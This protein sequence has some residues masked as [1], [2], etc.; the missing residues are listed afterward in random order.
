MPSMRFGD[1][2]YIHHPP[3][4]LYSLEQSGPALKIPQMSLGRAWVLW[5]EALDDGLL[6]GT[7]AGFFVYQNEKLAQFAP[8]ASEFMR[9]NRV[10]SIRRLND[11]R[12]AVGTYQGGILIL[13]PEGSIESEVG[14]DAGL[15]SQSIFSLFVDRENSIWA[16][17]DSGIVRIEID[18]PSDIITQRDGLPAQPIEKLVRHGD[19]IYAASIRS[20]FEEPSGGK[21]FKQ[22]AAINSQIADMISTPDGLLLSGF[23]GLS[24]ISED[25]IENVFKSGRS[26]FAI[27]RSRRWPDHNLFANG[28]SILLLDR[29]AKGREIVQGLSAFPL[30]FAEDF[31]GTLWMGTFAKGILVARPDLEKSVSGIPVDSSLGLPVGNFH[32]M[33][34][35]TANGAVLVFAD[36]GGW[37]K[38]PD[39]GRFVPIDNFPNRST[40]AVSDVAGDG[41]VWIIHPATE[42]QAATAARIQIVAG[43]ARWEPHS[44]ESLWQVEKP[45]SILAEANS[46]GSTTL[47]I[48][49]TGSIL[50]HEIKDQPIA[51]VPPSPILRSRVTDADNVVRIWDDTPLP[52]ETRSLLFEFSVLKF[53]NR[54]S[55]RVETL[56]VGVDQTWIPATSTSSREFTALRDGKY[57]FR[58]RTI[59]E[60]GMVSPSTDLKFS[61]LPPW[62]RSPATLA[63]GLAAIG[64]ACFGL[65]RWRVRLLRQRNVELENRVAERTLELAKASA[66]KTEFVANMSHDIRNPLNGI[67][68]LTLAL[69]DTPLNEKQTELVGTLR[70]C[71][72][73]LSTLVDDVLDF[74]SIEAGRVELR[75]VPYS[76]HELL[77]S[78]ATALRTDAAVSGARLIV[79]VDPLVPKRCVGDA[80]RI[81]QILVNYVSNALKYAGGKIILSVGLPDAQ[82]GKIE[83]AVTDNGPGIIAVEQELLFTKFSRLRGARL[84]E[85]SGSGLGLASCRLLANLMGG[86][87]GV[88]SEPSRGARFH[89]ILPLAVAPELIAPIEP[90]L[91]AVKCTVLLVEDT[92][93][94]AWA[95]TAVL[96]RLGLSCDRAATGAEALRLF[97]AKRHNLVL[98]DRNLPDMDGT[99]IAR[100]IRRLEGVGAR[101]ILLAV[102]A[103]CT[104]EDRNLCLSAGMDAFVGKPLTPEKLRRAL[105]SS[106]ERYLATTAVRV[107]PTTANEGIDISLLEYLGAGNAQSLGQQI[108]L[109][110]ATLG[111]AESKL[112]DAARNG[113][114][115]VLADASHEIL[116]QARL[117]G[118]DGLATFAAYL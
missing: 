30:S 31:D 20:L 15:P 69:E 97:A 88:W 12:L 108:D 60:T 37:V 93:Y 80:S 16:T 34:A 29:H 32:S 114:R 18:S 105:A 4:G 47:W 75:P 66:A 73:Y 1:R 85:I 17:T 103:Y 55:L 104:T 53:A 68:G 5:M 45:V 40:S 50:R 87:V 11:R 62:W 91:S 83:F 89:V 2:I 107:A 7:T 102:T 109:F 10:T 58:V 64:P 117:V 95:A 41:S 26:T 36:N 113:N 74:A 3:T 28:N 39:F 19:K 59:A 77:H 99:E 115:Q 112:D 100:Q 24:R 6:L 49:G 118:C 86:T 81:Q 33:V 63:L 57:T 101:S 79:K 82:L 27:K 51:V 56:L 72:A 67:F 8:A 78:V 14:R 76:P 54:P 44:V 106:G 90:D 35:E 13:K 52:Y 111:V 38:L 116:S 9:L 43:K 25:Q 96:A 42:K 21:T 48:G 22:I 98:L 92:N 70:E 110:L 84:S 46:N 94:N 61:I 71:T 23:G 65:Y